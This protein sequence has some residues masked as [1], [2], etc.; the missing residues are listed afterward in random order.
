MPN[1]QEDIMS[2]GISDIAY[3]VQQEVQI[4]DL[5]HP[6]YSENENEWRKWRLTYESGTDFKDEYLTKFSRRE[7]NTDFAIRKG[8]SYVPAF[9]KEAVD[10]VKDSIFQRISDV[11]RGGGSKTYNKAINGEGGGVDLVGTTMNSFVGL[12]ILPELLSMGE[13][14]VF[15][16]MPKLPGDSIIDQQGL[17][18]YIYPYKVE[19]ILNWSVDTKNETKYSR[20]LLRDTI[21]D[22]DEVTGLPI[23]TKVRY[24]FFWIVGDK[25]LVHFFNED[26][27]PI[28]RFGEVNIDVQVLNTPEIPFT[29]FKI[30]DSLLRNIADYQI[31]LLNMASSDVAYSL[32]CNYPFYVEAYDPRVDNLYTRPMGHE[33][34]SVQI[35]QAGEQADAL[36][37]KA[38]E[39]EVGTINGRRIPKGLEFPRYINPD[40]ATLKVS[41]EKQDELKKDIRMLAK[42]A[43]SNLAP[44]MAS[45]ESKSFDERSLE[46]GLSAIGLAVAHGE[47]SIAKFWQM[48]EDIKQAPP[49]VKYPQKYSLQSDKDQRDEAQDLIKSVSS[50]PSITYKREALKLAAEKFVGSHLPNDIL[51]KIKDEIDLAD[52][53]ITD[54]KELQRDIELGLIDPE[55]ASQSKAYPKGAV[56]KAKIAHAERIARIAESQSKARGVDEMAGL[57]NTSR[58]E[59]MNKDEDTIPVKRTR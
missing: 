43:V 7:D 35:I 20:L 44:K 9:A 17:R 57:E 16:D 29:L 25:V 2:I 48:Y 56:E 59:K 18:P 53:I 1:L 26:S 34:D 31:T 51:T 58:E 19:D 11:T 33:K 55:S 10:D 42:L 37:S 28:D 8:I 40:P 22:I 36:A 21:L 15:T 14:G 30:S 47:R 54:A 24:R 23:D 32:N 6:E 4:A 39:I 50:N 49:S 3:I 46:A 45:A 41:M 52:V 38:Y 13:V 5:K 12:F 27:E